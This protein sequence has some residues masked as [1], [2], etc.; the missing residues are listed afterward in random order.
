MELGTIQF[1]DTRKPGRYG[2]IRLATG[3]EV[4]FH[5]NDGQLLCAGHKHPEFSGRTRAVDP[6]TGEQLEFTAPR[7][8]DQVVFLR[9]EGRKGPKARPWGYLDDYMRACV[10]ID[11]RAWRVMKQVTT[12]DGKRLDPVVLWEGESI[13]DLSNKFPRNQDSEYDELVPRR[14]F[15]NFTVQTWFEKRGD[16]GHWESYPIDPRAYV[17]A[18]AV[19]H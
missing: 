15:R 17:R 5:E 3:E 12:N 16:S 9:T 11:Q 2:F 6:L 8:G 1:F 14:R 19:A 4:F 7:K 10:I 18:R 13:E